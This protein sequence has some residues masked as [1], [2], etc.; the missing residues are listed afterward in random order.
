MYGMGCMVIL[1]NPRP[2]AASRLVLYGYVLTGGMS[3]RD[4]ALTGSESGWRDQGKSGCDG[5]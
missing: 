4:P 5:M 2:S 3:E 1:L